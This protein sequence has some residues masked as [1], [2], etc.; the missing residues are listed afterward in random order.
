LSVNSPDLGLRIVL[1]V[2]VGHRLRVRVRLASGS[3]VA[4]IGPGQAMA[5]PLDMIGR[6][7]GSTWPD[8]SNQ[9]TAM[10]ADLMMNIMSSN[11]DREVSS[12][13]FCAVKIAHDVVSCSHS[14]IACVRA[15]YLYLYRICIVCAWPCLLVCRF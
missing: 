5:R 8:L 10:T 14:K 4:S 11:T 12:C 1:W 13:D 3:G 9:H 7:A 15:Y 2:R 6:A